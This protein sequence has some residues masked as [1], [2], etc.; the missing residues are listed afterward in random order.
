MEE[1]VESEQERI[2]DL[3]VANLEKEARE[4]QAVTVSI[5]RWQAEMK[6]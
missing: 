2:K 1:Q 3:E 4:Y 5:S 6:V